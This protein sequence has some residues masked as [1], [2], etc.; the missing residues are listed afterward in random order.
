[1]ENVLHPINAGENK[2]ETPWFKD[3]MKNGLILGGIHLVV[4]LLLYA[5]LPSKLTGLSYVFFIL[6]LNFGFTIYMGSQWR[7]EIG[8]F[9]DY[10]PAFKYAFILLVF[11][12]LVGI[13]LS[14]SLVLFDPNFPMVMAESQR[15]T[16]IYW[17]SK[18][19]APE[20]SLEQMRD[21][22]DINELAK[23]YSMGK[24][25][26]SFGVAI[27]LYAVGALIMALFIRKTEPVTM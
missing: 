18:F 13:V 15:D 5:A 22:M 12:G 9:M 10:G 20:E 11:N 25:F 17:A 16:S 19:G 23:Q 27:C 4:V 21:Q 24:S 3:A 26:I 1:M 6:V 2:A 7:K 8:G 14:I